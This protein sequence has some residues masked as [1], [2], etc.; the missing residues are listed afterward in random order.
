MRL[1]LG[2]AAIVASLVMT[3]P[4]HA[5]STCNYTG[6][7]GGSWHNPLNWSCGGVPT[8]ADAVVLDSGDSVVVASA[9]AAAASLSISASA[10]LSFMNAH[11]LDVTGATTLAAGTVS[12]PGS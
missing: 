6:L 11:K 8:S 10:S 3:A 9:D 5:A 12:G 4:A 2:I 7:A 1:G